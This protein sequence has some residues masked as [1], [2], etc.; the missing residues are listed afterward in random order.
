MIVLWNSSEMNCKMIFLHGDQEFRYERQADRTLARDMHAFLRDKLAEH[1][2]E[3][4]DIRGIVRIKGLEALLVSA[5]V[6]LCLIPLQ[7]R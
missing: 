1:S 2:Q 6:W 5:S 7:I 4:R 3:L